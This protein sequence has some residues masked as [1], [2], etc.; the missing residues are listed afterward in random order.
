MQCLVGARNW[1]C[2]AVLG[3]CL[4]M[5]FFTVLYHRPTTAEFRPKVIRRIAHPRRLFYEKYLRIPIFA[6]SD[7]S[8]PKINK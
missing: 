1:T 5:D 2:F 7:T 8:G 6:T 3:W 4:K